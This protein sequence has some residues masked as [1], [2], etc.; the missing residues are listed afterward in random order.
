MRK[1]DLAAAIA[2]KADLNKEE[3]QR[4]LE[5]VLD[6]IVCAMGRKDSINL[7]GFGTFVPRHRG[8][9]AGKNPQTGESIII[10]ASNTVAF[11]PGKGLREAVIPQTAAAP[12]A[13]AKP[14]QPAQRSLSSSKKRFAGSEQRA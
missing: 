5:A 9:R 2:L 12:V 1:S 11:K 4:V 3:A 13:A 6:Q 8:A 10:G 7:V 14:S